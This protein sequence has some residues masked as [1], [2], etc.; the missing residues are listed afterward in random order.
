M[1]QI[2]LLALLGLYS[3]IESNQVNAIQLSETNFE[4]L[5]SDK[6]KKSKECVDC[7]SKAKATEDEENCP[8]EKTKEQ[9]EAA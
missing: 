7:K 9:K 5:L 1:K 4:I 8:C 3:Q 2:V 6:I